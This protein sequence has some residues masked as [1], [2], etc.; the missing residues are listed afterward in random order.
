MLR[1]EST[2]ASGRGWSCITTRDPWAVTDV[3]RNRSPKVPPWPGAGPRASVARVSAL[4]RA[5][6]VVGE[7]EGHPHAAVRLVGHGERG[8]RVHLP[9]RLEEP[10]AL[11][12][13]RRAGMRH[14][15]GA[16]RVVAGVH[17]RGEGLARV[18]DDGVEAGRTGSLSADRCHGDGE[19]RRGVGGEHRRVVAVEG[20]VLQLTG[21]GGRDRGDQI[22]SSL[23][24][25][26]VVGGFPVAELAEVVGDVVEVD[27]R[28]QVDHHR[29]ALGRTG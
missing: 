4:V 10:A 16:A 26:V 8:V 17:R 7:L 24:H 13:V 14:G 6:L 1:S 5:A 2:D 29:R 19:V 9:G 18:V 28:R 25:A 3:T 23:P 11:R 12:A 15:E 21:E 27:R 22:L 20:D